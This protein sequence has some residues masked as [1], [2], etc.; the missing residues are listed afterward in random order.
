MP[1]QNAND[2]ILIYAVGDVAVKRDN[3]DSIFAFVAPVIRNADIAFCQVEKI[4][5]EKGEFQIG[6][7]L[8]R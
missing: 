7:F 3:P 5:A 2:R 8:R 1:R 6:D 4:Y